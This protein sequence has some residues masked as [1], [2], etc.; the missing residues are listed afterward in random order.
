MATVIVKM[1]MLIYR[2]RMQQFSTVSQAVQFLQRDAIKTGWFHK[3]TADIHLVVDGGVWQARYLRG[4]KGAIIE[5][6]EQL[7][8]DPTRSE[9]G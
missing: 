2:G 6:L 3:V 4:Q 9:S 5:A 7:H 8:P 1:I